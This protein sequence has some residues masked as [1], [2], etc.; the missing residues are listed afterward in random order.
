MEDHG[1][2]VDDL[3]DPRLVAKSSHL[4][5]EMGGGGSHGSGGHGHHTSAPSEAGFMTHAASHLQMVFLKPQDLG[6]LLLFLSQ[7]AS[8]ITRASKRFLTELELRNIQEDL[9][10]LAGNCGPV[11]VTQQLFIVQRMYRSYRFLQTHSFSV[12]SSF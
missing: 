9:S 2:V 12:F 11:T 4:S 7:F 5:L 1:L 3:D 10:E 8:I 6:V